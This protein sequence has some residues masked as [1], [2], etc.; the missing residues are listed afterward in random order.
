LVLQNNLNR[1]SLPSPQSSLLLLSILRWSVQE[2]RHGQHWSGRDKKLH[3]G[4][5]V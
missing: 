3:H 2:R 4:S 5:V 1:T